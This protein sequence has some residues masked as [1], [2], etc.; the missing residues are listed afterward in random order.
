MSGPNTLQNPDT[1]N[2]NLGRG[3]VFIS[4]LDATGL[5]QKW[6]NL[7]NAPEF[8]YNVTTTTVQHESSQQSLKNVDS[9][10]P[11]KMVMEASFTIDELSFENMALFTNGAKNPAIA[12]PA[13]L[14]F[15]IITNFILNAN[16]AAGY[17]YDIETAA[18]VRAYDI[19]AASVVLANTA[20]SPVTLVLTTDYVVDTKMGRF[21][22][23]AAGVTKASTYNLSLTLNADSAASATFDQVQALNTT[24]IKRA[25]KFISINASNNGEQTEY[26]F[27]SMLVNPTGDASLIADTYSQMGFKGAAQKNNNALY[28][29][30]PYMTISKATTPR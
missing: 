29:A 9:E 8:K 15:T 1:T 24:P 2:Y 27:H 26:E 12:N 21:Q 25:V 13:V 11:I 3:K 6:R 28:A 18:G 20:G 17:W 23:T 19:L 30:S 16:I 22:L 7:G 10:T 4:D 5:P 14:G